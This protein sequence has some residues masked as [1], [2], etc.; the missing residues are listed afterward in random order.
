[1]QTQVNTSERI[2][3]PEWLKIRPPSHENYF[4]V[5]KL[6]R[7]LNLY[8]VCEEAKCPN[9]G[10]C[11]AGGTAT[12]MLLGDVC[13]RGCR[14]CAVKTGNPRGVVD[15][16]EP[17]HVAEAISKLKLRYVV[18]TSVDRDDLPD[19][20]SGHF[21]ETVRE[22]KIRNSQLKVEVLT[23]DF[24]GRRE[25]IK[26]IVEAGPDV[27]A[28]NIETVERL[29]PKVR[30]PRAK[31]HQTL[32]VLKTVKECNPNSYTKSSIML[33][34][35]ET[36]EEIEQTL[37]DL[38]GAGCDVVTFGQ[39]LQPT[40]HHLK[41]QRF[42]SPQEFKEWG[43]TAEKMGFLYVASGPMVRSS[44]KAAEYFLDAVGPK[45]VNNESNE[46]NST[47]E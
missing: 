24:L 16:D 32:E 5:K 14:F 7:S 40:K 38:R 44:Y 18:I 30:D 28:H 29:T 4:E 6:L 19:H 36:Q 43:T 23:P 21:A 25:W 10:E 17:R 20:G 31:Y 27:Y 11:W 42:V 13:T 1:M 47:E 3:K 35:G 22:L 45:N 26:K 8:S 46:K 15:A 2:Q 9:I 41:V 12:F 37:N 34:L 33:G 39:Y